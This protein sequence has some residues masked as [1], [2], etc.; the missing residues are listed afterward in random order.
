M[1]QKK[2]RAANESLSRLRKQRLEALQHSGHHFLRDGRPMG[3]A[4]RTRQSRLFTW[5]APTTPVTGD[6]AGMGTS[7]G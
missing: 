3:T 7:K 2:R 5:S 6:P 4:L 1:E